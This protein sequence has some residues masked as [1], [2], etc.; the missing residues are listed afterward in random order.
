MKRIQLHFSIILASLASFLICQQAMA[1]DVGINFVGPSGLGVQDIRITIAQII[2]ASLGIL[3]VVFVVLLIISGTYYWTN[4]NDAEKLQK[5]KKLILTSVIGLVI[6][7]TAVSA[8]SFIL[9]QLVG[10]QQGTGQENV[11]TNQN[12]ND[13]INT[14]NNE[15]INSNG[16]TNTNNNENI[17]SPFGNENINNNSNENTNNNANTNTN[18]NINSPFTVT[19]LCDGDTFENA[20]LCNGDGQNLTGSTTRTLVPE[21]SDSAKCEYVCTSGYSLSD[22]TCQPTCTGVDIANATL[23]YYDNYDLSAP[24]PKTAVITCTNDTKC[25]YKCNSNYMF[26]GNTCLPNPFTC[27]GPA[28][29]HAHLCIGD[30]VNLSAD[31]DKL[32]V[33]LCTTT[34]KCEYLC[35]STYIISNNGCV[36]NPYVCKGTDFANTTL[37]VGS[38]I[39]LTAD[40]NKTLMAGGCAGVKCSY[41]CNFGFGKAGGVCV[42][43]K[44]ATITADNEY[45]LYVNGIQIGQNTDWYVAETYDISSALIVGDNVIAIQGID[46]GAGYGIIAKF[47]FGDQIYAST[48]TNGWACTNLAKTAINPIGWQNNSFNDSSWPSVILAPVIT[49]WPQSIHMPGAEWIWSATGKQNTKA[50]CRYH[51]TL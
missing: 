49:A 10:Q 39:D 28:I 40:T 4:K 41:T 2:Q 31:I 33:S 25:E 46:N 42:P 8:V 27:Q 17:N 47:G 9:S 29:D 26:S 23:C 5:A 45:V 24:I 51:F 38:N 35:N 32:V 12:G 14:N 20:V 7:L 6:I 30:G 18:E 1:V 16:N 11:N 15:N 13:N 21:C 19:Y 44:Y 43:I 36:P 50:L 22:D 48:G 37:C 34:R 3:G